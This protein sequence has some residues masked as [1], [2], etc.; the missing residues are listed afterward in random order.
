MQSDLTLVALLVPALL[1]PKLIGLEESWKTPFDLVLE[2]AFTATT[3]T[4]STTGVTGITGITGITDITGGGCG[5]GCIRSTVFGRMA[6]GAESVFD[7]C[8]QGS[9][10]LVSSDPLTIKRVSCGLRGEQSVH[11]RFKRGQLGRRDLH[12]SQ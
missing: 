1:A 5:A 12:P 2:S 10:E 8:I 4:T 9:A 11:A 3:A 7:S 6:G